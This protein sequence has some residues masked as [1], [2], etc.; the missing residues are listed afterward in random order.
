[1]RAGV[2]VALAALVVAAGAAIGVYWGVY[3]IAATEQ[4]T[5]PVYWLL[6][7][8]MRRSI[9]HHAHGTRVPPLG[10]AAQLAH[11]RLL[12]ESQCVRCHGAPGIAP[13]AFALGLRPLPANLANTALEWPPE[14]IFWTIRQGVK[15]T[16]MP[17][18][19]FRLPD[20]DLWA[21]VAY[22]R[23]LPHIS[24]EEYVAQGLRARAGARTRPS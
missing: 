20:E 15:A 12:Y 14:E 1:M 24:P 22:V 16:G 8:A 2:T 5:A 18:W 10:D 11:G 19:E 13:D 9:A 23:L 3:D 21:I 4:H 6:K 7:A 17:G